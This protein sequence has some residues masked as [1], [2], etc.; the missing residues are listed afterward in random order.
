MNWRRLSIGELIDVAWAYYFFSIQFREN[1]LIARELLPDDAQLEQLGSRRKG[2]G[3]FIS[4]SRGCRRRGASGSRRVHAESVV[5]D[6]DRRASAAIASRRSARLISA[7]SAPLTVGQGPRA[8]RAMRTGVLRK[9][10][11][12]CCRPRIGRI[13][14][15][16]GFKHFLEKHIEFDSDVENGHGGL[17]RHLPPN[18][19]VRELWTAFK[20]SLIQVAPAL[21]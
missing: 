16:Q 3:Q 11:G 4:L 6:A 12:A 15:S 2:Y 21:E 14:C 20:E 17:C 9:C 8:S 19:G 7:K 13:P 10:S 18:E 5:A 1:L